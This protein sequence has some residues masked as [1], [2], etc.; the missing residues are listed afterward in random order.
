[1]TN[2]SVMLSLDELNGIAKEFGLKFSKHPYGWGVISQRAFHH[3][4]GELADRCEDLGSRWCECLRREPA[5]Y[6]SVVTN[7]FNLV[8]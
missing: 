5:L 1:M 8:N 3:Q 7:P 4:R 6:Y 2:T